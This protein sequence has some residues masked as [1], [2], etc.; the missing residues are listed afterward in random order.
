MN[1]FHIDTDDAIYRYILIG[2][3]TICILILL[4]LKNCFHMHYLATYISTLIQITIINIFNLVH[5]WVSFLCTFDVDFA[6]IILERPILKLHREHHLYKLTSDFQKAVVTIVT[7]ICLEELG[8]PS[9]TS[10][11]DNNDHLSAFPHFYG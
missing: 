1:V 9:V 3:K 4:T 11:I 8:V 5:W 2:L 7:S 10:L 6:R